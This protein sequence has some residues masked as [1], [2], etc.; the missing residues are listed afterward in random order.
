MMSG[1]GIPA[2]PSVTAGTRC[3]LTS[4]PSFRGS[5]L[6]ELRLPS[7]LCTIFNVPDDRQN[8]SVLIPYPPNPGSRYERPEKEYH[9][10]YRFYGEREKYNRAD[11][12][13]HPRVPFHRSRSVHRK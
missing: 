3:R 6:T 5:T 1:T 4:R 13:K 11:S 2:R 10:Y 8:F 7:E 9:L 12:R